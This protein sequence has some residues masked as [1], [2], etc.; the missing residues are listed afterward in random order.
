MWIPYDIRGSLKPESPAGTIRLSR[1]DTSPREFLVGFFLR[2]PVTQAWELDIA[3][4]AS[5]L[6]LT[7][8]GPGG[9]LPLRLYGN[10]AGK[11][12][13]AILRV[14]AA[15]AEAAL[16]RAHGALQAWLLR[17]VVET[18]RGMAIAGW[19]IADTAHEARWRCTPFRPSAMAPDFGAQAPLVPDL[20]P[21]AELFQR[22]RNAPDAASRMLA[23]YAVLCGLR[24]RPAANDFRVTQEMLIH[25]GAME[26]QAGLQGLDLAALI[27]ALRPEHDRL[28][29]PGGLLAALSDD[30]A[31]QQRLARLANLAD[32]AAH[33]LL[34]A[35]LRAR[36]AAPEPMGAA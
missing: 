33:R 23:A 14:T 12:A 34:L 5:G 27:A 26:H 7:L 9:P 36:A 35:Q 1:T 22:A 10:E 16:A 4:P 17:Q 3:I 24:D 6:E 29:A 8:P 28:V 18:G 21:L 15:S 32:L 25:A 19:R 13:E 20:L 31:A 2:N 30:L 11:L